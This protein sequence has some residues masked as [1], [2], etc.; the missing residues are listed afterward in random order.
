VFYIQDESKPSLIACGDKLGDMTDELKPGEY[1]DEFVSGGLKNYAY[2]IH[3]WDL[4]KEPKTVCNVQGITLNYHASRL[5]NFDVI[6]RMILRGEPD[7]VTVRT[8][9]KIKRKMKG[10]VALITEPEEKMYRI[11]FHKRRRPND[12]TSIPYG[13]IK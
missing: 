1:I 13:Y 8:E 10:G 5:V 11:S 7:I 4:T 6:R 12:N 3:N 9:K 2:K